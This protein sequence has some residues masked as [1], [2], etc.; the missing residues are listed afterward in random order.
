MRILTRLMK[1]PFQTNTQI[2]IHLNL[3]TKKSVKK[4]RKIFII[5]LLIPSY[6]KLPKHLFH[7]LLSKLQNTPDN[8]QSA[9][10]YLLPLPTQYIKQ[11][12]FINL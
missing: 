6:A 3:H 7:R 10:K 8:P 11:Q 5:N 1:T 12:F 9:S 4:Q 2:L